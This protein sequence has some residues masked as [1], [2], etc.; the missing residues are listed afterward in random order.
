LVWVGPYSYR[1]QLLDHFRVGRTLFIG[2]SAHAVSPFG[3]R[4]GNTGVQDADN[5]GWK[6]ALVL[7]GQAPESLIDSYQTERREAAVFNLMTTRRTARFLQPESPAEK[8]LRDA[9]IRLAREYPFARNLCNTGRLSSSFIYGKPPTSGAQRHKVQS[10]DVGEAVQNVPLALPDGR[11][12]AL[13][14]LLRG[15]PAFLGV[16]CNA[17][18]AMGADVI[19][20]ANRSAPFLRMVELGRSHLGLS[21][22]GDPRGGLARVLGAAGGE[23]TFCL[24]RPDMHLAARLSRPTAAAVAAA[25]RRARRGEWI[26]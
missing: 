13:T 11:A 25:Y 5:L 20:L 16:W 23:P 18:P 3:A 22:V 7:A 26:R 6:L 4:G 12:G 1:A 2:D 21:A 9:V 19:R 10:V 8:L 24:I 15:A 14:D 17:D